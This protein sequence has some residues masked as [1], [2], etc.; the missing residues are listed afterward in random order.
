M[1]K[2]GYFESERL[3]RLPMGDC[4]LSTAEENDVPYVHVAITRRHTN[5]HICYAIFGI[6]ADVGDLYEVLYDFNIPT[7]AFDDLMDHM[8]FEPYNDLNALEQLIHD[9]ELSSKTSGYKMPSDYHIA[10]CILSNKMDTGWREISHEKLAEFQT[11]STGQ[12]PSEQELKTQDEEAAKTFAVFEA[13][14]YNPEEVRQWDHADWDQFLL[15]MD[16]FA[17]IDIFEAGF[18]PLAY[19]FEK[20]LLHN[21]PISAPLL[22][23]FNRLKGMQ[24]R[25]SPNAI[26]HKYQPSSYEILMENA[27]ALAFDSKTIQDPKKYMASLQELIKQYPHNP[28]FYHQLYQL[29]D[30]TG[31]EDDTFALAVDNYQRFPLID[32]AFTGYF[33]AILYQDKQDLIQAFFEKGYLIEDHYPEDF[34]FYDRH[35]QFYYLTLGHYLAKEEQFQALWMLYGI[36]SHTEQY[37]NSKL[38]QKGW[39]DLLVKPISRIV[40]LLFEC[41]N[42][43]RE[44]LI[45][46]TLNSKNQ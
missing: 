18:T 38:F 31:Q 27:I 21:Y 41:T 44:A 15:D 23:A 2:S 32:F 22:S 10:R 40:A 42:Q 19:L 45:Q 39:Q 35:Y 29:Y 14:T 4:F 12:V 8:Q 24:P 11:M 17:N 33:T 36:I 16:Q 26:P 1:G 46:N 6:A 13:T 5:G 37:R 43:Q 20:N 30:K 3:A 25:V 34:I 7:E 28:E 9:A